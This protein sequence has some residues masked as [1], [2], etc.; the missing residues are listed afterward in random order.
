MKCSLDQVLPSESGYRYPW[1]FM[2]QK[3]FWKKKSAIKHHVSSYEVRV[4]DT[5]SKRKNIFPRKDMSGPAVE[6]ISLEMKQQEIDGR[7]MY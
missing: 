5:I 4:N 1:N 7:C 2:F 3:C 6:A